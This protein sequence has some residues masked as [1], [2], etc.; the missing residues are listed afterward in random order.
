MCIGKNTIK[1]CID[2]YHFS[3]EDKLFVINAYKIIW[4]NLDHS[5]MYCLNPG[6]LCAVS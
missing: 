3:E 6:S 2:K 5:R 1:C 4:N